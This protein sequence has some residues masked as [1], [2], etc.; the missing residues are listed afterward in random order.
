MRTRRMSGGPASSRSPTPRATARWSPN[1]ARAPARRRSSQ[2]EHHLLLVVVRVADAERARVAARGLEAA[3]EIE[4]ARRCQVA[5]DT[6]RQVVES[7]PGPGPRDRR[8][9]ER[10]A[11]APA[12]G[13]GRDVHAPDHRRMAQLHPARPLTADDAHEAALDSAEKEGVPTV[14]VR[15]EAALPLFGRVG[16]LC[17]PTEGIGMIA[18]GP[19]TQAQPGVGIG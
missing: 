18:Q 1:P 19:Q 8:I 16:L 2:A 4:T 12:A 14:L 15:L 9:E 10:G 17:R 7:R 11:D 3:G 6:E 13:L 5:H